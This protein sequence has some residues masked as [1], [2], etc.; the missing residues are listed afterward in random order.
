MELNHRKDNKSLLTIII[1]VLL[2]VVIAMMGIMI[3]LL[4]SKNDNDEGSKKASAEVETSVDI[5]T[6]EEPTTVAETTTDEE[7]TVVEPTT[8]EPTTE[9]PATKKV[10]ETTKK[11][12]NSSNDLENLIEVIRDN[13]YGIQNNL[14]KFTKD[15]EPGVYERWSDSNG[16]MRKIVLL[17][18]EA[19]FREMTNEYYYD[20]EG[21]FTFAF[22]YDG[23]GNEYRYYF[24][25]GKLYRYIDA[26]GNITDYE[27]GEDPY[28]T[29]E[30]GTIYSNAE[31]E[32][33]F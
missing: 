14:S 5:T 4:T 22:V 32:K 29:E 8:E 11:A 30:I 26:S 2:I 15:G 3:F 31:R 6:T 27:N 20:S 18:S 23:N 33:M 24:Y 25:E 12:D 21:N 28:I 19:E 13:Y 10:K 17:P 9:A 16:I 7:T 1:I